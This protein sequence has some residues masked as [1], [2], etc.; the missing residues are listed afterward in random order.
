MSD[1]AWN[2]TVPGLVAVS[3]SDGSLVA[4]EINNTQFSINSLPSNTRAQYANSFSFLFFFTLYKNFISRA[5]SWSPKG[6]Q[7]VVARPGKLVQY[8]PDLKEAKTIA[9][10][11]SEVHMTTPV[12]C[13]LQWL[14]TSQFLVTF[15]D[16]DDPNSRP[17]LHIVNV[18][19][20]GATTF[21]DYDDVCYGS[22]SGR[23]HK[24]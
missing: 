21:I 3:L 6:K 13:G 22:P 24:Y 8:K 7:I 16:Q 11:G 17:H 12:A 2:P 9:F 10:S 18:Q 14:S 23:P 20:S 15:I 5:I 19:K 1:C 4:V